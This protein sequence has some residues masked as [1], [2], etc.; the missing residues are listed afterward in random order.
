MLKYGTVYYEA[1]EVHKI[2]PLQWLYLD[3]VRGLSIA[4]ER[5]GY[6]A[7]ASNTMYAENLGVSVRTIQSYSDQLLNAGWLIIK[8]NGHR[9]TTQ[10]FNEIY[11]QSTKGE[12]I[13]PVQNLHTK[14][15]K[16]ACLG[17]K[18]LHVRGEKIAPNNNIDNNTDNYIDNNKAFAFPFNDSFLSY[19]DKW[20]E[21]KKVEHGFKFKSTVSEETSLKDLHK[22]SGGKE[23]LAIEL[24]DTAI[25]NGWKGF[26]LKKEFKQKSNNPNAR[27]E[28]DPNIQNDPNRM[29]WP[30]PEVNKDP[31]RMKWPEY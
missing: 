15:E 14:G 30:E 12:K 22:K 31:D 6:F 28:V 5:F 7:H 8:S 1:C 17:V 13:A 27:Y 20:K 19:W 2:K 11:L 23:A 26:F 9:R 18:K 21:Y 10:A 3:M 24:I 4:N 16:S 25:A 29:K